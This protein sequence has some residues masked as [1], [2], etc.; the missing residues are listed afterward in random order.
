MQGKQRAHISSP[1]KSL[2]RPL[3]V[4]TTFRNV[5]DLKEKVAI[6]G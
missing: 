3:S 6:M 5:N 4:T 1:A 2:K